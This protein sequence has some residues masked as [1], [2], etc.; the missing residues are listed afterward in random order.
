MLKVLGSIIII[1]STSTIGFL[2]SMV[3][4]ERISQ[5]RDI[6]YIL[7]MLE[8]EVVFKSTPV[9][10]AFY[11]VSLGCSEAVKKLL[12]TI[13]NLLKEKQVEGI[14]QAFDKSLELVKSELYLEDEEIEVI[15]TF[16]QTLG[17]GDLEAQKKNFNITLEKL[18][19]FEKNAE[20]AKKKKERLYQYLG[21][22][23]GILIVIILI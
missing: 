10:E 7:N 11:N 18:K 4:S 12:I 19:T 13:S 15:R 16:M 21:V 20:E 1:A 23:F 5:I 8:S 6:Q 22:S 3:F 2:Y 14:I 17:I 9:T